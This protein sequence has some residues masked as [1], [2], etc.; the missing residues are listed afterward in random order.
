MAKETKTTATMVSETNFVD[1]KSMLKSLRSQLPFLATFSD[2]EVLAFN[3][4]SDGDKVFITDCLNEAPDAA[5]FLPAYVN[6]LNIINDDKLHN[7]L[8]TLED[9]LFE[10]YILVRRNR[11]AAG[12]RAYSAVSSIYELLRIASTDKSAAPEAKTIFAR[13]QSYHMKKLETAKANKKKAD[14]DKA[15]AVAEAVAAKE[16]ELTAKTE[17]LAVKE[18][19]FAAKV[20]AAK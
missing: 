19:E 4:L 6:I 17:A 10:L 7:E 1:I 16:A 14:A 3:K 5:H 9:A 20:E 11:M 15:A 12:D 2:E 8:W 18:A 13:L